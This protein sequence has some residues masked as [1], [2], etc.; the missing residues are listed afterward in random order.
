MQSTAKNKKIEPKRGDE[1]EPEM[2]T[3]ALAT[4]QDEPDFFGHGE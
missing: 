2:E 3:A 1:P 4:E